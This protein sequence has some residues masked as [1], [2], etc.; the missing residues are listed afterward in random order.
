MTR[1]YQIEK[2]LDTD[3]EAKQHYIKQDGWD[4][5]KM[6]IHGNLPRMLL[7]LV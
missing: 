4:I 7:V 3:G 1:K 5:P 6:M 2:N